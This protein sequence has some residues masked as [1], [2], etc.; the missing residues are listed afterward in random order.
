MFAREH[1]FRIWIYE[2]GRKEGKDLDFREFTSF[3]YKD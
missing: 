2:R 1:L 3:A